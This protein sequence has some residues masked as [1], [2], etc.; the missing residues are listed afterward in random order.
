M[1]D[2]SRARKAGGAGLGLALCEQIVR[3][4]GGRFEVDSRVGQGTLITLYLP[5]AG[6]GGQEAQG[7]EE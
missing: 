2:K 1:V 3:I 4:H 6:S 5:L 7:H